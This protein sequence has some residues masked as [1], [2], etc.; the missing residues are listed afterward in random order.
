MVKPPFDVFVTCD[1][2][3]MYDVT[4]TLPSCTTCFVV[5][6]FEHLKVFIFTR[7]ILQRYQWKDLLQLLD[8][9][10]DQIN[11]DNRQIDG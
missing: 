2:T 10:F 1:V 5:V 9:N 3:V 7:L 8:T 6:T 11:R 4:V